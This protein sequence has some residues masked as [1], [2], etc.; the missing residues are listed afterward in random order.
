MRIAEHEVERATVLGYGRTGR[1]VAAY[2]HDHGVEVFVS[3]SAPLSDPDRKS[4]NEQNIPFEQ[5]GHTLRALKDADLIV[6][7]PGIRPNLPLL[8]VAR[9]KSIPIFSELDLA[10]LLAPERPLIAVTGT[11]GKSTTVKLIEAI[12]NQAGL[13]A[14]A[15]GN[16][17]LPFITLVD[18]PPNVVVLEVSSFQLEQSH[19]FHPHVACLLNI[20]P[21]HL[22]R[23]GSME[24]YA[25]VKTSIFARQTSADWAIIPRDARLPVDALLAK[26]VYFEDIVLPSAAL[27]DALPPHNRSNLRAAIGCCMGLLP[28]FDA[29]RIDLSSLEDA[30]HLPFRLQLERPIG[31]LRVINDSK[32]TNAAST[33]T[34][35]ESVDSTCVLI[36]GGRHKGAGYE[37]LARVIVKR[38]VRNVILFGEGAPLLRSS[39]R[40]VGYAQ[41]TLCTTLEQALKCALQEAR[42]DDTILFSPACSSYDQYRNYVERGKHF[43]RLVELY[44]GQESA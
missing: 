39:L 31:A 3:D 30:F 2:L 28:S 42:G 44:S 24:N 37:A 36:L 25:A 6:L 20:A 38:D 4:L 40:D 43:S 17:G 19:F 8:Q 27:V 29:G 11:N 13:T 16:I 10:F 34:A 12:L 18:D 33:I 41:T 22:D 23:H 15:A 5:G 9:K 32:S 21:D 35:L 1:A 7:S 14:L 26:R